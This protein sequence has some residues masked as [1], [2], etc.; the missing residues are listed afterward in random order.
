MGIYKVQQFVTPQ[1]ALV[2]PYS[3]RTPKAFSVP[4]PFNSNHRNRKA[5]QQQADEVLDASANLTEEQKLKAEL[6]DNKINALGFSAVYAA[7]S[8]GLSLLDFIH[9][10]FL[11]N[12]AAF[13]AGIFIWKEKRKHDAVRP[14]SAINYL[15]RKRPVK[16]WGGPEQGTTTLPANEWKSY[17]EEADHPEYPSASTCFCNAHAESARRFLGSDNLGFPVEYPAGSSRIEPGFTPSVDTTLVFDTWTDFANDCGQSRVWAGV[18]FQAAIDES[19]AICPVFGE[20]AYSYM[21]KL[22]DG[23]AALRPPSAGRKK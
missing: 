19:K 14:F 13:D 8:Q 12:M 18:H 5:Y 17:L 2:E 11:T 10:D 15:Y 4:R 16:A 23:S 3:Y 1:Y 20:M 9:L 6:F 7:F 22:I 21:Q